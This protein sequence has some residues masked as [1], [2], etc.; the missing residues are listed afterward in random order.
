[1][2]HEAS[3]HLVDQEA[4]DCVTW[5]CGWQTWTLVSDRKGVHSQCHSLLSV[6][7]GKSLNLS[8][9]NSLTYQMGK[10]I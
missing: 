10:L 8:E 1:M 2:S 4:E 3:R 7:V 6:T 9:L 5:L